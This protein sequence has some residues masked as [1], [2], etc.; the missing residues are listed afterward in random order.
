MTGFSVPFRAMVLRNVATTGTDTLYDIIGINDIPAGEI[1]QIL[2][3][4]VPDNERI[5]VLAGDVLGFAWNSPGVRHTREG[6]ANDDG[7]LRLHYKQLSPDGFSVNDRFDVGTFKPYVR[8]Y[9]IKAIVS[10]I[11]NSIILN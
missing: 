6:E 8:A 11:V 10:G 9:S 1:D 5:S 7:A 4:Q 3:Y 2:T